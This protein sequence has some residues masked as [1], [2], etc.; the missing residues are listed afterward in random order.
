M[1]KKKKK[2]KRAIFPLFLFVYDNKLYETNSLY[3]FVKNIHPSS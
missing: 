3:Q 1:K 2:K